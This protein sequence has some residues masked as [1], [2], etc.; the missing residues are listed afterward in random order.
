MNETLER[1]LLALAAGHGRIAGLLSGTAPDPAVSFVKARSGALVPIVERGGR[2]IR[3][4]GLYDPAEDGR[5]AAGRPERSAFVLAYGL[6]AAWHILPFLDDPRTSGVLCVEPDL[7]MARS[8]VEAVDFARVFADPRFTLLVDADP[9]AA[10]RELPG[11]FLPSIHGGL[12]SCPLRPRVELDRPWFEAC[13]LGIDRAL[14][15]IRDDFSVQAHFGLAWFRNTVRNLP[16]AEGAYPPLPPIKKALVTAAGPSLEDQLEAVR[17]ARNGAFLIAT[18]TSLPALTAAGLEPDLV[19]SID[20]QHISYY[21]FVGNQPDIPLVLDLASPPTVARRFRDLRFV[22]SGHP[23]C[24]YVSAEW[25]NFPAIDTS[26]GNVAMAALSLAESLGAERAI[27]YGADYSYPEGSSYARGTYIHRLFDDGAGRLRPLESAFS[28]FLYRSDPL[29]REE[30]DRGFRYVS[31]PLEAYRSRLEAF[32]ARSRMR[33][34]AADGRG[35]ALR[36]R[37][38]VSGLRGRPRF[39]GAGSASMSASRFLAKYRDELAALGSPETPAAVHLARVDAASRD[40]WTTLL[41][42]AAA[43]GG[44]SEHSPEDALEAARRRA[45]EILGEALS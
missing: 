37:G 30:D 20:C 7:R 39:F 21:H 29:A 28:G 18:D 25:R 3:L 14:S 8:L 41:P 19:V 2:S 31:R 33:V 16:L 1:N 38:S 5:R 35:V 44:G 13:A 45:L 6:G 42:L 4:H 27:L 23:F 36:L 26:G 34:S 40:L 15:A 10:G 22:S 43:L 11:T 12:N 32:A 17:T 24:R 9:Q